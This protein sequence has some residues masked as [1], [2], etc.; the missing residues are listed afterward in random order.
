MKQKGFTTILILVGI[1]VIGV[2]AGGAYYLGKQVSPK[3]SPASI[4]T[5]QSTPSS[6]P[7]DEIANWKTYTDNKYGFSIKY[8]D[9]WKYLETPTEIYKTNNPQVW[10]GSGLPMP[11][12]DA[13]AEVAI[14]ISKD[15]PS[16]KWKPE[17]FENYKSESV[18]LDN[19][20]GTRITGNYKIA[21][22]RKDVVVI[23]RS[24]DYYF[25]VLPA[26]FDNESLKKF[27][28]ILST[29]KFLQ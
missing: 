1:L 4:V 28:Q 2:V 12:T 18:Q 29:F 7:S 19:I 15:D 22:E 27:N 9:T 13:R 20:V 8:P 6:V 26:N 24:K 23:I 3:P 17:N 21:P 5:S 14:S 25:E 11:Q 10:F 16:S